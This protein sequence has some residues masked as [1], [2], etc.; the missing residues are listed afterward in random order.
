M[1]MLE[2]S[3]AKEKKRQYISIIISIYKHSYVI[4]TKGSYSKKQNMDKLSISHTKLG[5]LGGVPMTSGTNCIS[6]ARIF[7]SQDKSTVMGC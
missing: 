2:Q 5:S 1:E 3:K 6:N 4:L 7:F